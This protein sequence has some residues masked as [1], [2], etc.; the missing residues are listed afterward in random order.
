MQEA[1]HPFSCE[2]REPHPHQAAQHQ[3]V[4]EYGHNGAGG[5]QFYAPV[6]VKDEECDEEMEQCSHAEERIA[7]IG[8]FFQGGAEFFR[9]KEC[10]KNDKE[11]KYGKPEGNVAHGNALDDF[12]RNFE[13][14]KHM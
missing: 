13:E 2:I 12:F 14:W 8:K 10:W 5:I 11:G 1:F 6:R 3:Q 7:G 4:A 9:F